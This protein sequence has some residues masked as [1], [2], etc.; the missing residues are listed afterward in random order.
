MFE[1]PGGVLAVIMGFTNNEYLDT[2]SLLHNQYELAY[3]KVLDSI[4]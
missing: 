3:T 1:G 4:Q 2:Y